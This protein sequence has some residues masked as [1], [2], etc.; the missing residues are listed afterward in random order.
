MET[1][2]RVMRAFEQGWSG[3]KQYCISAGI[4]RASDGENAAATKIKIVVQA[5]G[6]GMP[7]LDLVDPVGAYSAF[8]ARRRK[9]RREMRDILLA[10]ET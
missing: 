10:R 6:T 3:L 2:V 7:G 4:V 8:I 9:K 1:K 5:T